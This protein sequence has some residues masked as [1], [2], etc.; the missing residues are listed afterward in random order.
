MYERE[1][2]IKG[3]P[4]IPYEDGSHA[5]ILNADFTRENGSP[6]MLDFLRYIRAGYKGEELVIRGR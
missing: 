5:Y 6:A 3:A 2:H 4:A 1:S